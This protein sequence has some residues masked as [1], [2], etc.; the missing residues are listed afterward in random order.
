VLKEGTSVSNKGQSREYG[1]SGS[2]ASKRWSPPGDSASIERLS[3]HQRYSNNTI[4]RNRTKSSLHSPQRHLGRTRKE[5]W[6]CIHTKIRTTS[7]RCPAGTTTT[8]L[9][10]SAKMVITFSPREKVTKEIFAGLTKSCCF[11]SCCT[12]ATLIRAAEGRTVLL[13]L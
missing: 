11:G 6:D 9:H 7:P 5:L 8:R 10:P 2:F 12:L 4:A 1:I 13:P 3:L